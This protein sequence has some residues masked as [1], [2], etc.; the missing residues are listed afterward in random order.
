MNDFMY[1]D[2]QQ[3]ERLI[4]ERDA[5]VAR[6]ERA[7]ELGRSKCEVHFGQRTECGQC[8][9]SLEQHF[10]NAQAQVRKLAEAL[11]ELMDVDTS[12]YGSSNVKRLIGSHVAARMKARAVLEEAK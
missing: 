2:L 8:F 1:E 9:S 4:A 11:R 3:I 5:A 10:K 7:E 12:T 6:A